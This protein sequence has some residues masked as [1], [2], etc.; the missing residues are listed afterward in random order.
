MHDAEG[1][2]AALVVGLGGAVGVGED[3]DE[4]EEGSEEEGVGDEG[5]DGVLLHVYCHIYLSRLPT[6]LE[7]K[8]HIYISPIIDKR[9]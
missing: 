9:F 5:D 7:G 8:I 1:V 6:H 3:V 2:E 4:E